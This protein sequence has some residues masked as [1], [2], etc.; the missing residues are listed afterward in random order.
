MQTL[1]W[2]GHASFL[3]D[4][5]YY[6]DPFELP[7]GDLPK[8][9]IIFITHPHHDHFSPADIERV[10]TPQT[11]IVAPQ[12]CL[13]TLPYPDAQKQI[14]TPLLTGKARDIDFMTLPAYNMHPEKLQF[15]PKEKGWVGFVLDIGGKRIYHA[16]DTDLIP[17]MSSLTDKHVDLALLPMGGIYTMEVEEAAQAANTIQAK[18]TSPMHYKR[19]LQETS[20]DA[21]AKFQSL[22]HLSQVQI[23]QE[24]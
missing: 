20:Q 6:I 2:L 12:E 21:E 8:A 14:V 17:E 16:G 10:I 22:V 11:L 3:I 4:E 7:E 1:R 24:K 18:T 15:H 19:L 5:K 23:L 13:E 9:D